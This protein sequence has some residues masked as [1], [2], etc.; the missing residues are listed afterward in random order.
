MKRIFSDTDSEDE[1]LLPLKKVFLEHVPGRADLLK[2][3][4]SSSKDESS[5]ST[6]SNRANSSGS[7][8]SPQGSN[9]P[10]C[11]EGFSSDEDM[12]SGI[13]SLNTSLKNDVIKPGLVFD[14]HCHFEFI[15][16]RMS[17]FV[18]LSECLELDGEEL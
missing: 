18:Y 4:S 16:K 2:G 13:L 6:T 10:D 17:K 9:F 15:Q 11:V 7:S 1:D 8:V 5:I 14:T 3:A 12:D